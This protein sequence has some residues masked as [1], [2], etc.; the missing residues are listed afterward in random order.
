VW[1]Y[2]DGKEYQCTG[3]SKK[4]G[5]IRECSKSWARQ[6]WIPSLR[7]VHSSMS[8]VGLDGTPMPGLLDIK[9]KAS[10]SERLEAAL[11]ATLQA[12][13]YSTSSAV[14]ADFNGLYE[15]EMGDLAATEDLL[16]SLDSDSR[17]RARSLFSLGTDVAYGALLQRSFIPTADVRNRT[18][19]Y[20]PDR[21]SIS[22]S[23][24]L[25]LHVRHTGKK[26][27]GDN[28]KY[29]SKCLNDWLDKLAA[30]SINQFHAKDDLQCTLLLSSDRPRTV[31]GLGRL[32]SQTKFPCQFMAVTKT[33]RE[34]KGVE[35]D[36]GPWSGFG[37]AQDLYFLS[38]ARDGMM[39]GYEGKPGF[40]STYTLLAIEMATLRRARAG[41]GT[42]Y[43][44]FHCRPD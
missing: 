32:L 15:R 3:A 5:S 7:D 40:R 36:H 6:P 29:L 13:V 31:S 43:E 9:S 27:L 42:E 21:K 30:K 41:L 34:S 23:F 18:K 1:H 17:H 38:H 39:F 19:P 11:A 44:T 26:T 25:G 10:A 12:T 8:T 14:V 22:G 33:A 24:V 2:C 35:I 16:I 4:P 37:S 28:V 20:L